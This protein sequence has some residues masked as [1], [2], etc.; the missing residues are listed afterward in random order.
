[1]SKRV[2]AVDFDGTLCTN[3]WPKIGSPIWK[4]IAAVRKEIDGGSD[5]ILWTMREGEMLEKAV[6]ACRKWGIKFAAI[7]D[8]TDEWKQE[9]GNNPR[10]VGATEYWDDRA[11]NPVVGRTADWKTEKRNAECYQGQFERCLSR[12]NH[13]RSDNTMLK[14]TIVRMAMEKAG[15]EY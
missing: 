2:I 14:E 12:L 3:E 7:N 9:F 8:S 6:A 11:Y 10:K 13:S 1:M 4:T 15:V 5:I